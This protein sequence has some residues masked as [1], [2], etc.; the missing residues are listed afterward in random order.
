MKT[1]NPSLAVG[2]LTAALAAPASTSAGF[3]VIPVGTKS[4]PAPTR[5]PIPKTGQTE[6]TW[7]NGVAW[8]W[9]ASCTQPTRPPGQD[10]ELKKG[11]ELPSPRFT[12]NGDGTVTDQFTGLIWLKNANCTEFFSGDVTGGNS[13]SWS[14]ALSAANQLAQGFCGLADNSVAGNW[15][16]PNRNELLSLIHLGYTN[17]ALSNATGNDKW[18]EGNLFS[19][20]AS[21]Y[22]WSST[23]YADNPAQAWYANFN[24]GHASNNAKTNNYHV[25]PVR[26]GQ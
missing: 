14:N 8:E 6:C 13:R 24:L 25:W 19:G 5:P 17:P 20:V 1:M 3:Y 23:S 18:S 2:L 12:D 11:A 4:S 22:Y 21:G 10:G 9:D 15:R 7:D 26:N 16:L